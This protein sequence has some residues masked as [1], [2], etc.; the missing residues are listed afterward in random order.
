MKN[1]TLALATSLTII[2]SVGC[3]SSSTLPSATPDAG[4]SGA[5][6][7][8]TSDDASVF[9]IDSRSESDGAEVVD[10]KENKDST[11]TPDAIPTDSEPSI[12]D[13][14]EESSDSSDAGKIDRSA[15]ADDTG[16]DAKAQECYPSRLGYMTPGTRRFMAPFAYTDPA[17]VVIYLDGEVMTRDSWFIIDGG[18]TLVVTVDHPGSH[19]VSFSIGCTAAS[20]A[21]F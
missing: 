16:Y 20:D 19:L 17:D 14:S 12:V 9:E 6:S 15:D 21:H 18:Y 10:S 8:D 7:S 11:A 3:D 4:L 2:L 5:V 1:I 13:A